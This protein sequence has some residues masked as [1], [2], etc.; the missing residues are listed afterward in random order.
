MGKRD[1]KLLPFVLFILLTAILNGC[2][3]LPKKGTPPPVMKVPPGLDSTTT[4]QAYRLAER[5]FVSTQREEV[6][7]E[8]SEAGKQRLSKVDEFWRY[9]E[10]EKTPRRTLSEAEQTQF[11][12]QVEQGAEA[13]SAGKAGR[14]GQGGSTEALRYCLEAQ[15]Y[16]ESALKINPFEKDT[17]MLLSVT[18]YYLQNMFGEAGN[19]AKAV[20]ILERLTRIEKGE[21][22]LFRLLGENYCALREYDQALHNFERA[23]GVLQ[24]TSFEAPPDTSV[25]FSYIYAEGDIHAR[26]HDT[27]KAINSFEIAEALAS[28]EQERNDVQNYLKWIYWDDGNISSSELWDKVLAFEAAQKFPEMIRVCRELLPQL[29]NPKAK[30]SVNHK[31]AVMEFEFA[32]NKERAVERMRSVFEMLPAENL[33]APNEEMQ[34]YLNTYGAML[35]RLGVELRQR[36]A[37]KMAL[38]Y[39]EKAISFEWDQIGKVYFELMTLLWND[40]AQ[41]IFYGEKALAKN[42]SFSAEESC[43]MMSLMT[44]AHKSAGLFDDARTYFNKWKECQEVTYGKL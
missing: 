33:E 44:K 43:E 34:H 15:K 10:Q 14:N 5:S 35:Y 25:I 39:F 3:S 12:R 37:R 9:L 22:E 21:H 31:L 4:V 27:V 40:P 7:Q 17:R 6:A 1:R 28:T 29:S 32:E 23:L 42:S 20:E 11:T 36:N 30:M 26:K 19:Y 38:A 2:L 41:A 8:Y 18:Y 13:L 24:D 16:F